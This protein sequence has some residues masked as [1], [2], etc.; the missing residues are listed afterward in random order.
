LKQED[1]HY[2]NRM[3]YTAQERLA[4]LFV[5][6]TL[7]VITALLLLSSQNMKLLQGRMEY[8]ALMRNPVGVSTDT[9]VRISGI[10][11]GAVRRITLLPDN[12]FRIVLSVYKEFRSLV[13]TDSAASVSKLALIGDSVIEISPGS[14]EQALLPDGGF[15]EVRETL[16]LDEM[17]AGMQ[18]MLDKINLS[19]DKIASVLSALPEDA[20]RSSIED[21]A[22]VAAQLRQGGGAAG[23]LLYDEGMQ[24]D[25]AAALRALREALDTGSKIAR[26][27]SDIMLR[28]GET[29]DILQQQMQLVPEM[30]AKTQDLIDNARKT[31]E[32]IGNTWPVSANM[33]ATDQPGGPEAM[34]S[35]D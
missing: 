30:T 11:A 9:R 20:I 1:G 5:L 7:A 17:F 16:S 12:R 2:V 35:N 33:P 10:E 21:A 26:D 28:L 3:N 27:G 22:S 31:V 32:A 19:I 18:P 6:S 25:L 15:I 4:G 23:A 8:I 24:N 29:A 13:R 34:A 14:P